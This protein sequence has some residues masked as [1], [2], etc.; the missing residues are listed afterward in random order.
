MTLDELLLEWSYR[1]ERGYPSVDNPSDIST[2]KQ[3]LSE[4]D[5]PTEEILNQLEVKRGDEEDEEIDGLE[6]NPEQEAEEEAEETEEDQLEKHIDQISCPFNQEIAKIIAKDTNLDYGEKIKKINRTCNFSSYKPIKAVLQDKGYLEF[7]KKGEPAELKKFSNELQNIIEDV[8]DKDRT[9]FLDYL[10]DE[11]KQIDF[12]PQ[13]GKRGNLFDDAKKTGISNDIITK[14][15]RHTTQDSGKKGVGMGE[16]ALS[17]LFKNVGAAI[18]KGDLSLD[19]KEFEIKGEGATLGARPD[20]VNVI[21]LDNIAKFVKYEG[22]DGLTFRKE[23]ETIK[24]GKRKGESKVVTNLY[25]KGEKWTMNKFSEILADI[26]READDKN[27]FKAAFKQDLK[28]IDPVKK[29]LM[30]SA[31]DEYFDEI[32]WEKG[33]LEIQRG[34][35]LLNAYRYM[36]KEGFTRFLAHDF[37]STGADTGEYIYAEGTPLQI[38][39]QLLE[40]GAKFEKIAPSNLKPRIGFA[41]TYKEEIS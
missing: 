31:V 17:L 15:V 1:S 25:F 33:E 2:L 27:A 18:G 14:L 26:Y 20:T 41:R 28:D 35:A 5:I 24:S 16:L 19:G 23:N 39:S 34:I 4:L 10:R 9:F 8:S 12:K 32:Q 6:P 21:N 30:A 13:P 3:I 36:L 7:T 29:N 38:V 37:G 40:A 22:D 11:N